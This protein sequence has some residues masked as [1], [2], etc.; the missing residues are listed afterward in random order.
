MDPDMNKYDLEH[1]TLQHPLMSEEQL[2]EIYDRA[3]HLYYSREHIETLFRRA[4]ASGSKA[5]RV[6]G[7]IVQYYGSY[8]FHNVHPLQCGILRTKSRATMRPGVP[9]PDPVSFYL[10]RIWNTAAIHMAMAAYYL[11][12]EWLRQRIKRQVAKNGY[13]DL[14]LRPVENDSEQDL[15]L[16]TLT[17][18]AKQAVAKAARVKQRRQAARAQMS[19]AP[20]A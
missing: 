5:H 11:R 9:R 10:G 17:E 13:S 8:R 14:S 7:A 2:Q 1:V 16:F 18:G 4:E 3:W 6:L 12:L 15:Q 19:Q 20:D